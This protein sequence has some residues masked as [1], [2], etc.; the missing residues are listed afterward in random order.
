MLKF[1]KLFRTPTGTY[2]Y[3]HIYRYAYIVRV[4]IN[5]RA[6]LDYKFGKSKELLHTKVHVQI[7]GNSQKIFACH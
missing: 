4:K 3:L 2:L 7:Y 6:Q 5:V 1:Q